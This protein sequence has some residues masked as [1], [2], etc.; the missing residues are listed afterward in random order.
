MDAAGPSRLTC[1]HRVVFPPEQICLRMP[2]PH[3]GGQ[4]FP[5]TSVRKA[6]CHP[7]VR[8]CDHQYTQHTSFHMGRGRRR[9][10]LLCPHQP[11]CAP[12]PCACIFL[13][14]LQ[15]IYLWLQSPPFGRGCVLLIMSCGSWLTA[16][17]ST[18]LTHE[19]P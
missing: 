4:G 3:L 12:R 5:I 10:L 7:C 2:L 19:V 18:A 16:C 11:R 9:F 15:G 13:M 17:C 8:P 6:L 14:S 1:E